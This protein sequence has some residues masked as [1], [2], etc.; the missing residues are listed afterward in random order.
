MDVI[1]RSEDLAII[2]GQ[3]E[4]SLKEVK[5]TRA[6]LKALEDSKPPSLVVF[7]KS[8][9]LEKLKTNFDNVEIILELFQK[10][11]QRLSR[12]Q[13]QQLVFLPCS[14]RQQPIKR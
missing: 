13:Y 6:E 1:L 2:N 12:R 7:G 11:L 9:R 10:R 3:G 14:L 8:K 4:E 5:N